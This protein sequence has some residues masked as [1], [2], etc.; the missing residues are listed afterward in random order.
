MADL[1]IQSYKKDG[2]IYTLPGIEYQVKLSMLLFKRA[3]NMGYKFRIA[4]EREGA[5]K[6][7]DLEIEILDSNIHR[8]YQLKHLENETKNKITTG[9]LENMNDGRFS[10]PKYFASY[11]LIKA[12]AGS[13][14]M[15]HQ[16]F[17]FTNIGMEKKLRTYFEDTGV[18]KL[19]DMKKDKK[20]SELLK[21]K[22]ECDYRDSL[23]KLLKNMSDLEQIKFKLT[24]CLE[25]E[26]VVDFKDKILKKYQDPLFDHVFDERNKQFKREFIDENA[27]LTGGAKELHTCLLE[28]FGKEIFEKKLTFNTRI[29]LQK[30]GSKVKSEIIDLPN[31]KINDE[32]IT[33]FLD[34]LILAVNQPNETELGAIIEKTMGEDKDINLL[35]NK[36]VACEILF[37]MMEWTKNREGSYLTEKEGKIMFKFVKQMISKLVLIGPTK[38]FCEKLDSYGI[39]FENT[40]ADFEQFLESS[41]QQIFCLKNSYKSVFSSIKVHQ[42]LKNLSQYG[43]DDSYIFAPLKNLQRIRKRVLEAFET[44][45][46]LIIEFSNESDKMSETFASDLSNVLRSKMKKKTCADYVQNKCFARNIFKQYFGH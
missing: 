22:K 38:D 15:S 27:N 10:L 40:R 12:T 7:D 1:V 14:G 8:L 23:L 6:F 21:L 29:D 28:K 2:L 3:L 46:L 31:D 36:F 25:K 32:E 16:F 9:D 41:D 19:L 20:K 5:G 44:S 37:K 17:I 26:K 30:L 11:R 4:A 34:S 35:D 13:D 43:K 39:S 24:D 45:D 18:D 33:E 42:T